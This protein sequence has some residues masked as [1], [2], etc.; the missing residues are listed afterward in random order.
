MAS[1]S[2]S[3]HRTE[4]TKKIITFAYFDTNILDA[5]ATVRSLSDRGGRLWPPPLPCRADGAHIAARAHAIK[6]LEIYW[7]VLAGLCA[8]G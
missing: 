4:H 1:L 7:N 6:Q 5:R 2:L 3:T 8:S